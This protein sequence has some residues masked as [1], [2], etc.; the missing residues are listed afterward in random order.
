MAN[1]SDVPKAKQ[2]VKELA[3]HDE[4]RLD[5]YYWLNERENP[6]VIDY[7]NAENNYYDSNTEHI[8]DFQT[9]LFE[10]M[11]ARIK[12]DDSSVPYK[13]NGYWYITRFE[14]GKD[15]P[16][17]TRKKGTLSAEEE[18]L[19]DCN[20]L[21]KGHTYFNLRGLNVSPDNSMVAFGTDT[22][23]RRQ[24]TIQ[25]KN[26]QTNKI[27]K[28]KIS[29][30]TGGSTWANDNNT[31][32]YTLQNK[33]T[34]RSEA[35]YKHKL[36]TET[37]NDQL[38]FEEK[39]DTFG[40]SVY[41]TKSKKYLVISSYSTLS[42]EFQI[43]NA[44]TPDQPFKIFQPRLEGL[45]YSI[46]HYGD[47]FYVVS[48][49]DGAQNFK[50]SKTP[51][52]QTL[53]SFWKDVI[54]HRSD[55]L[56]KD[57]D[58]FKE[59][60]VVSEQKNGLNQI[61]VKKWDGTADY[62]I[63]FQSETYT[64]YTTNNIDFDTCLLRYGYESMTTPS[65]IIDFNM[66]SKE[67]TILKEQKVL[68]GKFDKENYIS[69][70]LWATAADGTEIPISLVK[71]KD[72]AKSPDTPLLLYAYGSYGATIDP[73]F[74]TLRLSLLDRGFIFAIA[75]VRGGQ[76]LGR[77]WYEDGKLL[78]KKNT[79]TD[80][81]DC[82]K[83]LISEGY[84][85]AKHHYA[86][87]GS[88]GGL[89]MG[90]VVNMAPELY[91]GVVSQVPFV[92]VVTTMLDDNIPLT[93]GE[94]DEWGNPSDKIYYDYMKSYSPYDNVSNQSYPNMLVTTGL[95]DSQVQYWEPAKWVARLRSQSRYTSQLYLKTN[96]D[97]GH[98]GASG[99]FEAIKEVASE[100]AFLLD[101]ESL[102]K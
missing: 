12:K 35:I 89:L 5:E 29:H 67:K 64:A 58:V 8:K 60:L 59:F 87:G 32:F 30:C 38:V 79:F 4:V 53:K 46:Y 39:D 83:F 74:S 63:P 3:I 99:R 43:L 77:Q 93:T 95:H 81:I 90:A 26:L 98:G 75:H 101:L 96:M 91:N 73:Y 14:N 66:R 11:K 70:R 61:N 56:L 13:H 97:A 20:E 54:P 48:N 57:I 69:Q 47:L 25:V 40:V 27:L 15:Y 41:K 42:T 31:L 85:S 65:S 21:A 23:G 16:I 33:T 78:K 34:L 52:N 24:Y 92:D 22:I 86:M 1:N 80:F 100:Y 71:H 94:Y 76:Y 62:Y 17:Y 45:E 68:G 10:E 50:L 9:S 88:A 82:S 18:L 84:T 19:L 6:K 102:V 2:V 49:A 55:V 7:L 37:S 36:G 44:D 51:E 28:D 72:T